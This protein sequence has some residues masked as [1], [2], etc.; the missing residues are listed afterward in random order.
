[1]TANIATQ[2]AL[3][4]LTKMSS[5]GRA[6]LER[7]AFAVSVARQT[8]S[9][10][11]VLYVELDDVEPVIEEIGAAAAG[12]LVAEVM[13]RLAGCVRDRDTIHRVEGVQFVLLCATIGRSDDAARIATRVLAAIQEPIDLDG[14]VRQLGATIGISI[15][16]SDGDK[17]EEL[18]AKAA[19][20]MYLAKQNGRDAFL[21]YSSETEAGVERT[22]K[23][24]SDLRNAIVGEQFVV[25]YQPIVDA[26]SWR[27]VGAEALIRWQ[28]RAFGLI[29]PEEFVPFAEEHGLIA[30]ID[31]IALRA[32]CAQLRRFTLADDDMF[33]VAVNVSAYQFRQPG[34]AET[35]SSI[36]ASTGV[37][38]KRLEIEVNEATV[39]EDAKPVFATLGALKDLGA[40]LS[41]DE[42]GTGH[43]SFARIENPPARTVKVDR[44]FVAAIANSA[45]DQTIMRMIVR[46]A[47]HLGL[48]VTAEGVESSDQVASLAALGCDNLQGH[49]IGRPLP[50]EE[51]ERLVSRGPDHGPSRS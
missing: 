31:A 38:P 33:S 19:S 41:I 20:A 29:R 26:A 25:H 16:P 43:G 2:R 28:H 51:F 7:L 13:M 36:L 10:V 32:A 39:S 48:R 45:T 12:R 40:R 3:R 24:E 8:G 17:P 22:L 35:V 49:L 1:M 34:F 50:A 15:S 6:V 47:H 11:A 4:S 42:F 37:D 44:S 5:L 14:R 23:L 9:H 46:L 27:I 18:I 30:Q 21:A